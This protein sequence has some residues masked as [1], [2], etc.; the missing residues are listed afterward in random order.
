MVTFTARSFDNLLWTFMFYL[1][2]EK[3]QQ[4][5]LTVHAI[6]QICLSLPPAFSSLSRWQEQSKYNGMELRERRLK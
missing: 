1:F 6:T 4:Q 5:L 3:Q 2:R